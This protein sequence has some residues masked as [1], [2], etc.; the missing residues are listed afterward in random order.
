M[1]RIL[2]TACVVGIVGVGVLFASLMF[3]WPTTPEVSM[4]N[5]ELMWKDTITMIINSVTSG[6]AS[7]ESEILITVYNP[8]R[9]G[10]AIDSI[11]GNVF[12]KSSPVGTLNIGEIDLVPGSASDSLGV[13]TFNGFDKI[14]EIYYDFNVLHKLIL[15]FELFVSVNIAGNVLSTVVPKFLMN[16]NDPPIQKHCKCDYSISQGTDFPIQVS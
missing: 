15:E 6:K 13:L 2:V 7:V 10:G 16:I 14:S 8:N 3:Y 4:C 9:L 12:Y 1:F 5:A 11:S